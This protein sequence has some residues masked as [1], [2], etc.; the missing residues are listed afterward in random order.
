MSAK[1]IANLTKNLLI[2]KDGFEKRNDDVV[3]F[4]DLNGEK[5]LIVFRQKYDRIELINATR[6]DLM[7]ETEI[8]KIDPK[9]ME[10]I[11]REV[12]TGVRKA[13]SD[14]EKQYDSRSEIKV[15]QIG[16][17]LFTE[18]RLRS[19]D[20]IISNNDY[21]LK[22]A[23]HEKPE[24]FVRLAIVPEHDCPN[25]YKIN[26]QHNIHDPIKDDYRIIQGKE[27]FH[28]IGVQPEFD[29][30]KNYCK[31]EISKVIEDIKSISNMYVTVGNVLE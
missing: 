10:K 21:K 22:T 17:N 8:G 12:Y 11:A 29:L 7:Y 20:F 23:A 27:A 2:T 26:A 9:D 31:S 18:S 5:E 19:A 6:N 1:I 24:N 14:L 16:N 30:D 4:F 28:S 13:I 15:K 3:K 25:T